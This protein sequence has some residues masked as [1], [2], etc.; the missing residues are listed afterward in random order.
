MDKLN[1]P[2]LLLISENPSVI[3]WIKKQLK[4]QFFILVSSKFSQAIEQTKNTQLDFVMIDSEFENLNPLALSSELS[5]I[6]DPSTPIILITGSLKKSFLNTA[7]KSGITD[8]LNNQLNSEELQ[9]CIL[10]GKKSQLLQKKTKT[11]S[12]VISQK[13]KKSP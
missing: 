2:T 8:F 5:S 12:S 7:F 3:F 11:A 9:A 4:D 6:L 10:K 13:K 1:L